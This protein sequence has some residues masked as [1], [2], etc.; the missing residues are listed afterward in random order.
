MRITLVLAVLFFFVL[1]SLA[2]ASNSY[3][4]KLK[5]NRKLPENVSGVTFSKAFN[6]GFSEKSSLFNKLQ[7]N[8]QKAAASRL[9]LYYTAEPQNQ[10]ALQTL[11]SL[12]EIEII[13]ANY[14]FSTE[15]DEFPNDPKYNEQWGLK[16]VQASD[17]WKIAT[18]KGVIIGVL[19][20]G[21]D[22]L[23]EDL[24]NQLWINSGEDFN[25][26][27]TFEPWSSTKLDEKTGQYGDL[28]GI[29]DD[30]NGYVDD[31]IGYDFV[32]QETANFGD[33]YVPDPIP[34]D[35]NGHGTQVA[36]IIAAECNNGI[37]ITG[38]AYES[39]IAVLRCFDVTGNADVDDIAN[40]V[41]YAA[42]NNI[43]VLNFS[44]GESVA[45]TIMHDAIKFAYAMGVTMVSS[46]GNNGWDYQHYPSDYPEVISVGSLNDDMRRDY[47]SNYG[48]HITL[49]A[50]GNSVLTTNID[51]S[52]KSVSGTSIA[53]PHVSAAAALLLSQNGALKPSEVSGILQA[54]A[55]DLEDPSWD[56]KTGAGALNAAA[57]LKIHGATDIHI[58]FPTNT[59]VFDKDKTPAIAVIGS[60]VSP[61]FVSYKIF[62]GIG[63][64]PK[65]WIYEGSEELYQK[66]NDTL[67]IIDISGFPDTTFTVRVMVNLD[68]NRTIEK[69]VNIE[70]ADNTS[71]MQMLIHQAQGY[72]DKERVVMISAISSFPGHFF[73]RYRPKG[74]SEA[75]REI[76]EFDY[77]DNYHFIAIGKE[78]EADTEMEALAYVVRSDGDSARYSFNF[79]RENIKLPE[80]NFVLKDYSFP[81]SY[82][83]N[84][85]RDLYGNN[86]DA[87][88]V[89]DLSTGLWGQA[90]TYEFDEDRFVR[91]DSSNSIWIPADIGDSNGDGIEEIFAK[92]GGKSVLFQSAESGG[93]P[94][95]KI[96]Y[97]DTLSLNFWAAEMADL[98]GDGLDELIGNSDTS[99]HII[100]YKN[101]YYS[102]T[103][104]TVRPPE[105]PFIGTLP[106]NA[107]ADID[108]DGKLEL[109][110]SNNYGQLFVY[111]YQS[112]I[113]TPK[114]VDSTEFSNSS[115]F[116]CTADLN[117]D[118][119]QEIV[120]LNYGTKSLYNVHGAGET[121][122]NLIVYSY[123]GDGT[124]SKFKEHFLGVR[125]GVT[126]S[127]VAFRNGLAAGEIDGIPGDEIVVSV[128]PN[129]YIFKKQKYGSN[130]IPIW[131]KF[132]AFSNSAII[133]DFDKNGKSE[134]GFGIA[135]G[136]VKTVFYEMAAEGISC[137]T[138]T[139]FEAW[140]LDES[141]AHLQ[142]KGSAE[143]E[144]YIVYK[145]EWKDGKAW[146]DSL[147]ATANEF[148]TIDGL[149]N[150]KVYEF[151]VQ[152]Y[153][154]QYENPYSENTFI[155]SVYT[156]SKV[157]PVKAVAKTP[158]TVEVSF[159]GLLPS[160]SMD[161][162]KFRVY[163]N[164]NEIFVTSAAIAS[165][166]SVLLSLFSSLDGD[167]VLFADSF[168]D[169]FNTPTISTELEIIMET[170]PLPTEL[171]LT[172][173]EIVSNTE[174]DLYFS[175]EIEM[176]S[177]S[178]ISNYELKPFGS[179][180]SIL[181]DGNNL[182]KVKIIFN[183]DLNIAP[184]GKEYTI[185]VSN[186]YSLSGK[187]ITTGSGNTLGFT[188]TA[189]K[190]DDVYVYPNPV[191]LNQIQSVM[192]ANLTTE[193]VVTIYTLDGIKLR[194][195]TETDSNGGIEWDCRN[196][197][198]DLLENG[199][200]LYQVSGAD[201]SGQKRESGLKK[202]MIIR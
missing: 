135:A 45:S 89:I 20:T 120:I 141:S 5:E 133:H 144:Y 69:R 159:S 112:G 173:L 115:Q 86:K 142:W 27:G 122:W 169:Y 92:N 152:A 9:D 145:V 44:F 130:L 194:E 126:R 82:L 117:A 88:A 105:Y 166:S 140:A 18:G 162:G 161:N 55:L 75:F 78:A 40:A 192:F 136:D 12:E 129:L 193:A 108:G 43:K 124:F 109:C 191:K 54:G 28:N 187:G 1:T 39:K 118:G 198:G 190:L 72:R 185:T 59:L 87:T 160:Q 102:E 110:H 171:Y 143:A 176:T 94:F 68:N 6:Y 46:S 29:D 57:A 100:S 116:I 93:N 33:Y 114:Y 184:I 80:K 25:K 172:R 56:I 71:P 48:S 178:V 2:E 81:L 58:S 32:H 77:Y 125:S 35:E 137:E 119:L 36:G 79:T 186:I 188:L 147:T 96:L 42:M 181:G 195:L 155:A 196:S 30:G 150:N 84:N 47:R 153:S 53:A 199:I 132:G 157:S 202:L 67:G 164:E 4:V 61:L 113:M 179:I 65:E 177:G 16:A 13:E 60:A 149:E 90:Y 52:Y 91:K 127:G 134:V 139:D 163:N 99:F 17:A 131:Y 98:D 158:N 123:N 51:N 3:I 106:G 19:D 167:Y 151:T 146:G 174:L 201:E 37:G 38:L 62:A 101:G 63:T 64:V 148:A 7:T 107:V 49:M 66:K 26:N 15:K 183:D 180:K 168:R 85:V 189:T 175:E 73:I 97:E 34:A 11:Y 24:V 95:R 31:I 138:P 74:S 83:N 22:F 121:V 165:D 154:S 14:V 200:Y 156:H 111:E 41:V 170:N 50:P 10:S 197:S 8:E 76:H 182:S 21:L 103:A 70:I 23:H 104:H 128:F